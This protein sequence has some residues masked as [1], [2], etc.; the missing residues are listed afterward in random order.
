MFIE[1]S[2][3]QPG[4][5]IN[6]K[7]VNGDEIVGRLVDIKNG[8]HELNRPCIVITT[9]EGLG[10]LQAMFGLDPDAENLTYKEEHIVTMCHTH[11]KMAEHYNA[12]LAKDEDAMKSVHEDTTVVSE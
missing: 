6:L 8:R 4:E 10:V 9:N 12:V 7:L 2:R 11:P 5:L 3:F 1:N